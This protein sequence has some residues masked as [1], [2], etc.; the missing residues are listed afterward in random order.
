[1]NVRMEPTSVVWM[2]SVWTHLDHIAVPVLKGSQEMDSLVLVS[3]M[4]EIFG[5][6]NMST[7]CFYYLETL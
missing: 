2:L 5:K 4:W 3:D 6:T 1:M 7:D